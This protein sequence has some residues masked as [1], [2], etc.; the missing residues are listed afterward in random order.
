MQKDV[1]LVEFVDVFNR[2]LSSAGWA[3]LVRKRRQALEAGFV[4][5]WNDRCFWMLIVEFFHANFAGH[6]FQEKFMFFISFFSSF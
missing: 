6:L 1:L 4:S 5:A 3:D 2:E